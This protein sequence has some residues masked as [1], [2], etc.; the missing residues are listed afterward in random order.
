MMQPTKS[1]QTRHGTRRAWRTP[2]VTK[3][4]IG[5][6]TKKAGA[7]AAH[8]GLQSPPPPAAPE[9]KLGFSFEMSLP[10]SARTGGG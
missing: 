3:L 5:A 6:A 10:L 8:A 2:T 1:M 9:S 4:A 7:H